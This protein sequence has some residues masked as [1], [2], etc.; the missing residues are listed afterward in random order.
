VEEEL[1]VVPEAQFDAV[2]SSLPEGA[3][4]HG[5]LVVVAYQSGEDEL[6]SVSSVDC[7]SSPGA[8][9]LRSA[10]MAQVRKLSSVVDAVEAERKPPA[11]A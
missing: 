8:K 1:V 9:A 3:D 11:E 4:I 10:I 2:V 7:V 5:F 6:T